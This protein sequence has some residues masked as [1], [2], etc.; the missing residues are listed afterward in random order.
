MTIFQGK[1]LRWASHETYDDIVIAPFEADIELP[2]V[3][4]IVNNNDLSIEIMHPW[5]RVLMLHVERICSRLVIE[6]CTS[7]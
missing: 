1:L 2:C 7:E 3:A 5:G 6:Q 4:N